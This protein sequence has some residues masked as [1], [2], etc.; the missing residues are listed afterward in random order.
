MTG[1]HHEEHA[2]VRAHVQKKDAITIA[3]LAGGMHRNATDRAHWGRVRSVV[4][5]IGMQVSQSCSPDAVRKVPVFQLRRLLR[6]KSAARHGLRGALCG[7]E[8]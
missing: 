2:Y 5:Y 1:I 4:R 8:P 6:R 3:P 7:A